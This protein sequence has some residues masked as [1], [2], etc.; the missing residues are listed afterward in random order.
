MKRTWNLA[1][2]LQLVQKIPESFC[3]SLYLSIGQIWWLNELW[4]KRYIQ[5]CPLSQVLNTV[6]DVIDLVN[7]GMIKNTQTWIYWER[8]ITFLQNKKILNL[9]LK[10]HILINYPFVAKVTFKN[11]IQRTVDTIIG[12]KQELSKIEYFYTFLLNCNIIHMSNKF[13]KNL[14]VIFL[15][16]IGILTFLLC[17][18]TDIVTNSFTWLNIIHQYPI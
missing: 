2:V 6:H 3:S 5:K 11:E 17:I 9:C 14:S 10:W 7:H 8:Y 15:D 16:L 1:L 18:S 12:E 4:F 13:N